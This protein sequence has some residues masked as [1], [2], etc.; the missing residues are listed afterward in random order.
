MNL[1]NTQPVLPDPK[2]RYERFERYLWGHYSINE[3]H[4]LI[5]AP[6]LH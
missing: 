4:H 2:T 1:E 6:W 5:P 3:N